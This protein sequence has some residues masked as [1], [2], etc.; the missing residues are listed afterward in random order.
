MRI[1]KIAAHNLKGRTFSLPLQ[2]A[3]LIYGD[4]FVGKTTIAIALRLALAGYLPPP[5]GKL[6]GSIYSLAGDSEKPGTLSVEV[7]VEGEQ[8]RLKSHYKTVWTKHSRGTVSVDGGVPPENALP[9]VLIDP[10]T[11][12]SLTGPARMQAIFNACNVTV[13]TEDIRGL[14]KA[15]AVTVFPAYQRREVLEAVSRAWSPV[16]ENDTVQV[17]LARFIDKIKEKAKEATSRAKASTAAAVAIAWSGDVPEDVSVKVAEAQTELNGLIDA[18]NDHRR[19]LDFATSEA[20]KRDEIQERLRGLTS[21][22]ELTRWEEPQLAP[23][24]AELF[25]IRKQLRL[26]LEVAASLKAER[27]SIQD[28]IEKFRA[29]KCP[30]CGRDANGL[31]EQCLAKLGT[32][33]LPDSAI[34]DLESRLKDAEE[35][36]N[37]RQAK[38]MEYTNDMANIERWTYQINQLKRQLDFPT[39]PAPDAAII[40]EIRDNRARATERLCLWREAAAKWEAHCQYSLKVQGVE[41]EIA[42][43]TLEEAL[44]KDVLA[45][46]LAYQKSLIERSVGSLL[47]SCRLFTDGILNSHLEYDTE[48]GR[49][50]S[51]RDIDLG[52]RSQIG[53]WISHE[54]FSGTEESLAYAAFSVA[55]ARNSAFRL[56]ILDEMGRM[57]N[58]TLTLVLK[59]MTALVGDGSIDQFIGIVA[60]PT[61][62]IPSLAVTKLVFVSDLTQQFSLV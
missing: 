9:P 61:S 37:Q 43:A 56:V 8:G 15:S 38:F 19:A 46:V 30:T 13:Q 26:E 31:T 22:C 16:G 25:A 54:A 41:K 6:S 55:M 10:K 5:I 57:D 42:T 11:F 58:E 44:Y 12:F 27:K 36:H 62:D 2:P 45:R 23:D 40:D 34:A 49:R 17:C 51:Q 4:N 60:T 50:V 59:R 52:C 53:A 29:G 33:V 47:D 32:I 21:G 18:E 14:V 7:D 28:A 39:A 48:L 35:Q 24:A 3:T 20:R 1:L